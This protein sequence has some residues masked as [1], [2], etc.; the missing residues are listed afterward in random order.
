V[1]RGED[2]LLS[3]LATRGDRGAVYRGD[4]AAFVDLAGACAITV[5]SQEEGVH[6]L[7]GTAPE[8]VARRSLAVNLSDAAAVGGVPRFAL[9]TLAAP[10]DYQH[11]RF[12]S[13]FGRTCDHHG[14]SWIGG[15]LSRSDRVRTTVTLL[16]SRPPG[17]RWLRRDTARPGD[18]LF[19]GG[20]V[21]ESA[22]GAALVG[23]GAR[24]RGGRVELPRALRLPADL[25]P[26]ARRAVRRHLEPR[27][28]LELGRQLGRRRRAAALDVSDGLGKDLGRLCRA[29]GC[30]AEVDLERLPLAA[31]FGALARWLAAD[32]TDLA[33]GGGEDYVLL[34]ALPASAPAPSGAHQIGRLCAESGLRERPLDREAGKA[35]RTRRLTEAGF[36]HLRKES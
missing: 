24:L 26:A 4:D 35:S 2:D 36:D 25:A 12:L 15:D 3:W 20:T 33:W 19:V 32:A 22:A 23:Q 18:R 1:T 11:Q 29:S 7:P 8:V 17:G 31:H 9:L 21:G 27:P 6:F 34:F 13:A 28:Q 5:D 10:A 30:G 14:V 16:A